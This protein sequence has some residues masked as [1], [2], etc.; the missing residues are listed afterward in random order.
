M[1]HSTVDW[2]DELVQTAKKCFDQELMAG[3][4]GNISV[5]DRA[6]Q[7]VYITP[8]GV[9]YP[10]MTAEDIVSVDLEGNKIAG[11]HQPSSEVKMHTI[12]YQ[13]R[14]D[15]NGI[16]HTHAPYATAFAVVHQPIPVILIEMVPYLGGKVQVAEFALPGTQALGEKALITLKNRKGVLLA[17]HGTLTIGHTLHEAYE[18]GIYLEDAAK[19]YHFA[20]Q[21]GEVQTLSDEIIA[22][23]KG[24]K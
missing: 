1:I 23:M 13:K 4:S 10:T 21:V 18:A 15:V 20:R 11:R 14:D 7:I 2:A 3:T 24:E 17:N 16:V 6:N 12:I 8:S 9:D 19:I 5:Y 22:D